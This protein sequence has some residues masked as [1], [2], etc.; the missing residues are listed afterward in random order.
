MSSSKTKG[1]TK[2]AKSAKA[3]PAKAG[4]QAAS[5][6][7]KHQLRAVSGGP[8]A[9]APVR[10]R[11]VR[12]D[13]ADAFMPDPEGGPA[14][15][16]DDLAEVLAEDFLEAATRGNDVLED[17]LERESADEVGGPFV[18]TRA[19]EELA[20][21]VDESNPADATAEPLPRSSA[22]LVQHPN[23]DSGGDDESGDELDDTG[24]DDE[25]FDEAPGA[26]RVPDRAH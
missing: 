2:P 16:P 1:T 7:K 18:V 14:R 6:S 4:K 23:I 20:F 12:S 21:D 24:V 19:R 5:P 13:D 9:E 22:G 17:D 25:A 8:R 3:K 10:T 26:A 15:A 11:S